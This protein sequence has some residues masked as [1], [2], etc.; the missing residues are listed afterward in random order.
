MPNSTKSSHTL[1]N[2]ADSRLIIRFN[3]ICCKILKA[4]RTILGFKALKKDFYGIC[5]YFLLFQSLILC[6]LAYI[7]IYVQLFLNYQTKMFAM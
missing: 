6:Q 2:L 7:N 1:E 5:C 4:R 3:I